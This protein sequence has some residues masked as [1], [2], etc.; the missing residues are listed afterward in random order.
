MSTVLIIGAGD[1]GERIAGGLAASRRVR[2]LVL[3]SR[4][5]AGEAAVTLASSYDCLVE[6]VACDARNPG[7]VAGLLT[8]T[9]PDLVLQCASLRSP[10]ALA[11]RDD[12]A[13]RAV[14]AAGF[15]LRLP[16]QLP[17]LLAVMRAVREV[18]YTGP[19]ANLSLPDVTGPVAAR[20]GLAPTV[21]LGNA[22][23]IVLRVR[24]A[25]RAAAPEAELPLVRVIAQH[26]QLQPVMQAQEPA[27][28]AAR[29]RVYVGEEGRRDDGLGY[30]APPLPLSVRHNQV[31]AASA[32]PVLQALLPGAAP[33]RWSAP[34]PAGLPG[35]YPVRI[36]EGSVALD[37]P[38]GVSRDEAIAFN[39]E[40]G[41]GDG[42]ERI[43]PDGTVHFTAACQKA[44]AG[45]DPGLAEP[46]PLSDLQARADR[47]DAA[48]A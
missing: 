34:A 5:G 22:T 13:A 35:G 8:R 47:L 20:V 40:R 39:Q 23:M 19:V 3:A 9:R 12:A 6:A 11:G 27:D 24:A 28:P 29:A 33:L 15:G 36:A 18:G 31:T 42:V 32:L 30:Q 21:G 45:I 26:S 2:R 37:L 4:S 38:P 17:V 48:L 1:L 25:L 43:D 7:D 44:V 16:Y 46:L 14:A 10:W 41:R